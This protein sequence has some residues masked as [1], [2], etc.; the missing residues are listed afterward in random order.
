MDKIKSNKNIYYVFCTAILFIWAV[1]RLMSKFMRW[2]NPWEGLWDNLLD[3]ERVSETNGS[4]DEWS[5]RRIVLETNGTWDR[6]SLSSFFCPIFS[7]VGLY[8]TPLLF[9]AQ[10]TLFE[11]LLSSCQQRMLATHAVTLCATPLIKTGRLKRSQFSILFL[12]SENYR[13]CFIFFT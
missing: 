1:E 3:F 6:Q 12:S 8:L 9:F 2:D 5:L 11:P 4:W 7:K 10:L 13:K